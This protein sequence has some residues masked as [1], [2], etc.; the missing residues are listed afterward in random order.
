M[1]FLLG[2]E[3][4]L[5]VL[6]LL[7]VVGVLPY[8]DSERRER[9]LDISAG[10]AGNEGSAG[11]DGGDRGEGCSGR[12]GRGNDIG[13]RRAGSDERIGSAIAMEDGGSAIF[14]TLSGFTSTSSSSSDS[15][16]EGWS[17]AASHL[18]ATRYAFSQVLSSSL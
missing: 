13:S 15:E 12:D 17:W 16:D 1:L 2:C 7:N 4:F 18:Q 11:R 8:C 14:E 3:L 6:E 9:L 5:L 10:S